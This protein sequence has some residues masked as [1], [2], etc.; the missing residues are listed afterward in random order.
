M[1]VL[2]L[3]SVHNTLHAEIPLVEAVPDSGSVG[4]YTGCKFL[5][6]NECSFS[7]KPVWS[8]LKSEGNYSSSLRATAY[9]NHRHGTIKATHVSGIIR[10]LTG[11]VPPFCSPSVSDPV[12][13]DHHTHPVCDRRP[14]WFPRRM[15]AL[16][17]LLYGHPRHPFCQLLRPGTVTPWGNL[18]MNTGLKLCSV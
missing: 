11:G 10:P 18:P 8:H 12:Y 7:I 15:P 1:Y 9:I 4:K 5:S 2:L 17:V 6:W 13:T 14:L 16:P 3:W